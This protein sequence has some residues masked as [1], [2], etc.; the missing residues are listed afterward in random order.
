MVTAAP[1]QPRFFYGWVIVAVTWL[2]N[3]TTAGTNPLV[4]SVFIAPMTADL[5][6]SKAELVL[7]ITFRMIA[8]GLFAPFL[9]RIV[10]RYGARW[11]GVIAGTIAAI[12]LAGLSV[13]PEISRFL[14]E[15]LSLRSLLGEIPTVVVLY[16]LFT[17]SGFS[18]FSIIGGNTLTIVPPANW[19]VA[20]R[21]RAI[22][23]SSAGQLLGSAVF[24]LVALRLINGIGWR[25]TWVLFGVIAF[26]GVVPMYALFMRRRPEDM[27]LR[28]DGATEPP[29]APAAPV[30]GAPVQHEERDYTTREAVRTPVF[31]ANFA[32][33]TLLMFAISPFLLFRPQYWTEIGFSA[34]LISLG[35]FIDPFMFAAANMLMGVYAERVPIR[36]LGVLGGVFRTVGI[37]PLTLGMTWPG[38]VIIHNLVWGIGSGTTSVFQTMM[39]P[40]YF[41]RTHQGSI[42]GMMTLAMVVISSLGGPVGGYMLDN[43]MSFQLF[44]W[45]ILAAVVIA[46]TSFFFQKPPRPIRVHPAA[47]EPVEAAR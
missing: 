22:A 18:G 17:L 6:L 26:L 10:D 39:I 14:N 9:G 36:Y 31:W 28:P 38:S 34:D 15:T 8:G 35:L 24:A 23:I 47:P 44:W 1:P 46:S 45:L 42:R 7:G 12:C 3:F 37:L 43:G 27:G 30:A 20:K 16:A 21:G 33:T 2:A 11:P 41:G 29:A 13:A 25:E 19:F 40:E 32:S 4:F 5:G